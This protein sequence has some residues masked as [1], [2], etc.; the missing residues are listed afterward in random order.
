MDVRKVE[1]ANK[2]LEKQ[3]NIVLGYWVDYRN[4]KYEVRDLTIMP[5]LSIG[6]DDIEVAPKFP[7]NTQETDRA[8]KKLCQSGV[9][10]CRKA[11]RLIATLLTESNLTE[12][13]KKLTERRR[14]D[15]EFLLSYFSLQL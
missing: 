15:V 3:L 4:K 10:V 6:G 2:Q 8:R 7:L 5:V 12:N 13:D 11:L 9:R 14:K 1:L